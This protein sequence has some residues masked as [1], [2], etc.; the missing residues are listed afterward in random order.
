MGH[1]LTAHGFGEKLLAGE[2]LG[3]RRP[4]FFAFILDADSFDYCSGQVTQIYAVFFR[5]GLTL[6]LLGFGVLSQGRSQYECLRRP[7]A[8]STDALETPLSF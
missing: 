2:E 5:H 1:F 3:D 8:S 4:V 7:F 6:F